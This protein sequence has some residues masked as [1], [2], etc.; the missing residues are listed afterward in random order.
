MWQVLEDQKSGIQAQL[1][2]LGALQS[3]ELL[4]RSRSGESHTSRYRATFANGT[5]IIS[6]TLD[7]NRRVA[8]LINREED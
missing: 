2:A 8:G 1:R 6:V 5:L 4:P 7:A 3:L